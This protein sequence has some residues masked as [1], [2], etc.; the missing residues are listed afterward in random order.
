MASQLHYRTCNLCE[1]MCGLEIEH[2]AGQVVAIRG[3]KDDPLSRGHICPKA[4]A[5][6]DLHADAD[7]LRLPVRRTEK[8]WQE[9]SWDEALSEAA[10][11][12]AGIQARHGRN[13]VA[14]YAGNPTVHNHGAMFTL[15][16][17]LQAL[18]TRN[19]YSATSVDQLPQML[20]SLKL[21]GHQLLLPVPDID[22]TDH[23]FVIGANPMA[24]N[25]SLMTAPDMRGRLK[26]LRQRG[27]KLVV[28]DPRRTE[29][30]TVADSHHFIQPGRD[31]V[32]LLAMLNVIFEQ[33]KN[34]TSA[35]ISLVDNLDRL[36]QHVVAWTPER[37]SPLCGLDA[38]TIRRIS[39]EFAD[40]KSAVAYCRVGTSTSQY[41]SIAAWLVYALN[42]VTGNLD[43]EGGL[44]FPAPAADMVAFTARGGHR[45]GFNRYRSRVRELPEFGGEFPVT[46]LAD[47]MLE[48]GEGQVKA[49]LTHAGNP[50]LS[51]PDGNRLDTALSQLDFMVSIDFYIN[52]T[53]RHADIILPPTG[54]LEH[55]QFDPV[56]H[57]LAVHN[58]IKFSPALFKPAQGARHDWH[59]MLELT[60][61]LHEAKGM[62]SWRAKASE[63]AMRAVGDTGLIDLLLRFGPYGQ[64]SAASSRLAGLLSKVPLV[65]GK[66]KKYLP[67]VDVKK[68]PLRQ[69]E[70]LSLKRVSNA[71]HGIDL[72]PLVPSLPERLFT[73][74][75]RIDL[76]PDLYLAGLN[77]LNDLLPLKED[78]FFLIGRRHVRS[79]N[80]WMHNSRRLVKGK[81][82]CDA[83]LNP[84]DAERL[85]VSDGELV[86]VSSEAGAISLPVNITEDV[87]PGVVSIPHGWGHGRKGVRLAVAQ[88]HAGVSV[89]DVIGTQAVEMITGMAVLNGVPVE[90][91]KA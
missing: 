33:K 5:L 40:A 44:M 39:I 25:G 15:L 64:A 13:A 77:A 23:F 38:E 59:I 8:G 74:N 3:D 83:M 78:A 67:S 2:D 91:C 28:I 72:G 61:R 26:A 11:R 71:P 45:G 42:I 63:A 49:L 88:R 62:P 46:T 84:V 82:R 58:T 18:G 70:K 52:E 79:N 73:K 90:I 17:L 9:I 6:Q 65:G 27:G 68:E 87:M 47:E 50:V 66:L 75:R 19:R 14:M 31:A 56:F 55:A 24:S 48:P 37:A 34:V 51:C 16:P 69:R 22:R 32:L 85:A 53:T 80:S 41:S 29:T 21:F 1:A 81:T 4:V 89:N 12:L 35:Q 30:A 7:R 86:S 36:A 20:A 57:G 54:H 76:F 10:M 60:R 43:R